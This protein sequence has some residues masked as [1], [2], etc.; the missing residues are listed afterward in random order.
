[1]EANVV[2]YLMRIVRI[3]VQFPT[4]SNHHRLKLYWHM[5]VTIH[6][7]EDDK[8]CIAIFFNVLSLLIL[9]VVYIAK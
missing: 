1:M 5:I 9:E 4:H 7:L 8:Q 6:L 2:Q 3:L